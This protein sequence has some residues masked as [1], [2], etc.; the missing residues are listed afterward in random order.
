M[1]NEPVH[2]AVSSIKFISSCCELNSSELDKL[3]DLSA[4]LEKE[5]RPVRRQI[6][7]FNLTVTPY[8]EGWGSEEGAGGGTGGE[9]SSGGGGRAAKTGPQ[10]RGAV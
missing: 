2:S 10:E 6:C 7:A 1:Y 9:G 3:E 5:V 8:P 4:S